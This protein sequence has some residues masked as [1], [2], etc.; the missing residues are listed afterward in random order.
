MHKFDPITTRAN[1]AN[2]ANYYM[3]DPFIYLLAK[4]INKTH[5]IQN[6]PLLNP[7]IHN[8]SIT[9]SLHM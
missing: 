9:T 3:S 4:Q 8:R 5:Y 6:I 7:F 2:G 1:P